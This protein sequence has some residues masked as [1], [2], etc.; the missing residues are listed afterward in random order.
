MTS[1]RR[2]KR[3]EFHPS[4]DVVQWTF[5]VDVM[6]YP[7]EAKWTYQGRL[8]EVCRGVQHTPNGRCGVEK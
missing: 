3:S 1:A 4:F 7:A 6:R 8:M 2:T 5:H